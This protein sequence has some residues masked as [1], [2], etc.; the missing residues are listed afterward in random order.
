VEEGLRLKRNKPLKERE[1]TL[2]TVMNIRVG[3]KR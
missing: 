1:S 3:G 2:D